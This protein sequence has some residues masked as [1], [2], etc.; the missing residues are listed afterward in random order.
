M[1][2][3]T[4]RGC[5]LATLITVVFTAA[6]MYLG[7]KIGMTFS[8]AIPAAVI[9]MSILKLVKDASI[10]ENCM[11][12]SF[13]SSAGTLTTVIFTLPG[14]V[15]IGYWQGFDYWETSIICLVGGVLGVLYSIP[16]RRA[17]VVESDLPYPEGVAAAAVLKSGSKE[18]TTHN[19]EASVKDILNA[20]FL[21]ALFIFF[22]NGLGIFTNKLSYFVRIFGMIFGLSFDLSPALIGAGYLIGLRICFNMLFGLGM[23]WLIF[24][25]YFSMNV[26][27]TDGT[28]LHALANEIWATKVRFIGVGTIAVASIWT[29][30][31]LLKP[32]ATGIYQAIYKHT[33]EY[34]HASIA[35]TE[36]DIPML[37]VVSLIIAL[38]FPLAGIIGLFIAEEQLPLTL[39]GSINLVLFSTFFAM[40]IG[41]FISAVCGYIAGVTGSS[42]SP[43][44]GI[45]IIAI[46]LC[47]LLVDQF[48][49]FQIPN[50]G[51]H[52]FDSMVIGISLFITATII[53]M[54]SVANDNLQDLKTGAIVKATPWKQEVALILGVIVGSLVIPPIIE[55]VYQAY[56]FVGAPLPRANMNPQNQLAAPQAALMT[57]IAKGIIEHDMQWGLIFIGVGIAICLILF[58]NLYLKRRKY[59]RLSIVSIGIGTYLPIEVVLTLALGGILSHV[60]RQILVPLANQR[61]IKRAKLDEI[62]RKGL[63]ISSGLIVGESLLGVFIAAAI[64]YTGNSTPFALVGKHFAPMAT[65]LGG[66]FFIALIFWVFHQQKK[67]MLASSHSKSI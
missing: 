12:Q 55:I 11:I 44:S 42:N 48:L 33:S 51:S 47:A 18:Q 46:I 27:D 7:L 53:A 64:A 19:S 41:F 66:I 54:G 13:A 8:S 34:S 50:Y 6:N 38:I 30:I 3:L 45:S 61:Q 4:L 28:S 57:S 58:D 14:L 31:T 17:L 5:L 25:P 43:I 67:A 23:S 2:E 65:L 56:G 39:N 49:S 16:L 36:K 21:S 63:L 9:S 37:Q 35:R 22:S 40:L 52:N 15:M 20:S 59:T 62:T 29:F 60:C 24:V 32:V 1:R 26:L 10:L